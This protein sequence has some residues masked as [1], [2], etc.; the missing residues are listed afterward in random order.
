MYHRMSLFMAKTKP[1][2]CSMHWSSYPL[3]TSTF[4]IAYSHNLPDFAACSIASKNFLLHV[5]ALN[6]WP[7]KHRSAHL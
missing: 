2:V 6:S 4:R 7:W 1:L 3:N 5:G